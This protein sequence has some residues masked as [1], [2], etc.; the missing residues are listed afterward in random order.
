MHCNFSSRTWRFVFSPFIIGNLHNVSNLIK[1]YLQE[2]VQCG[3]SL[4]GRLQHM[5]IA[6]VLVILKAQAYPSLTIIQSCASF[7][8]GAN[9]SGGDELA[10]LAT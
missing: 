6:G 3:Y 4:N 5:L 8:K 9:N 2:K 1:L 7:T 10:H